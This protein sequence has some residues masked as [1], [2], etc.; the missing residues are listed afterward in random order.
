MG[1]NER[2]LFECVLPV[3][4][5]SEARGMIITISDYRFMRELPVGSHFP[6][7]FLDD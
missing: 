4:I 7:D 2:L 1:S 6:Q 5:Q 3:D